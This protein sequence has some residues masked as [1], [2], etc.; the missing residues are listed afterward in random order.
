MFDASAHAQDLPH[1][2]PVAPQEATRLGGDSDQAVFEAS[3]SFVGGRSAAP[4]ATIQW[5]LSGEGVARLRQECLNQGPRKRIHSAMAWSVVSPAIL[6]SRTQGSLRANE[7]LL[8]WSSAAV[9]HIRHRLIDRER[10]A[11]GTPSGQFSSCI[12]STRVHSGSV[13]VR[14][15]CSFHHCNRY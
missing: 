1:A 14:V 7:Y 3:M 15:T 9:S 13:L 5:R 8:P 2:V 11:L 6:A 4:I 12:D 10:F